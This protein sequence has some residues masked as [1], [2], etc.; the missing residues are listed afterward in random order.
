MLASPP[1]G[2]P[3]S[4]RRFLPLAYLGKSEASLRPSHLLWECRRRNRG[5]DPDPCFD[6]D[7][8]WGLFCNRPPADR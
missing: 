3:F 5:A 6:G 7:L 1:V 4:L 2:A 8:S